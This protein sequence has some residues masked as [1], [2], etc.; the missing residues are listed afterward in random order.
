M[1]SELPAGWIDPALEE[2]V[3]RRAMPRVCV[4]DE[5]G[6]MELLSIEFGPAFMEALKDGSAMLLGTLP[7]PAKGQR[8]HEVVDAVKKRTDAKVLRIT[9]NNRDPLVAQ[10]YAQ[11]RECLGLG[12]PG[13]GKRRPRPKTKQE[14]LAERKA[15]EEE[16]QAKAE[17]DKI[18]RIELKA[19]R[20]K[21]AK[22][23]ERQAKADA[24]AR[25]RQK[26]AAKKKEMRKQ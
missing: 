22:R 16:R 3:E 8:D 6:K 13:T 23:R 7:Q 17:A 21:D 15:K 18:R 1:G 26:V 19:K 11:L 20:Q 5:V 12:P 25:I 10:A 24:E 14:I 2:W 9:R 4:C